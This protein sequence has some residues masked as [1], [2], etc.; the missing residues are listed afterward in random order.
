MILPTLA[1]NSS[2]GESLNM[3]E[4]HANIYYVKG[5]SQAH[6]YASLLESRYL[7][8]VF[9]ELADLSGA[10]FSKYAFYIYSNS[11]PIYTRPLED[12][13]DNRKK[14]LIYLSDETSSVPWHLSNNFLAIFK[15]YLKESCFYGNI[16]PLA[17]G[18]SIY[19]PD[20]QVLSIEQRRM[21]VFFSGNLN[22]NRTEL[23]RK[24]SGYKHLPRVA[25]LFFQSTRFLPKDFSSYY[26]ESY[27]KFTSGFGQG[28]S[29]DEYGRRYTRA[30]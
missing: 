18:Y 2:N 30:R 7:N 6:T 23:Y 24:L 17:L 19:I 3:V 26:S 22:I 16:F 9:K 11:N 10:D 28:L 13:S 12:I 8:G 5:I 29:G 15:C 1:N 14:I 21:N 27:I 20:R 25:A 4:E